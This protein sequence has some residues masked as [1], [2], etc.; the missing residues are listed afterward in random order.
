MIRTRLAGT[1]PRDA[2]KKLY[3]SVCMA[4]HTAGVAGAPKLG[5]KAAW[6]DRIKQGVATLD[7]HAIKGFQG[8][9]GVMP[10]KG[11][12]QASDEEVK[13]AVEYMIAAVK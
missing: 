11:G 12:S 3:D 8:K 9:G 6:A 2:G 1:T 10:P 7:E 5:D 13:A 4:C